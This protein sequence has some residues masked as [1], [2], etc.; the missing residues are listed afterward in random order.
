MSGTT[1]AAEAQE[2]YDLRMYSASETGSTYASMTSWTTIIKNF[3]PEIWRDVNVIPSAGPYAGFRAFSQGQAEGTYANVLQMKELWNSIGNFE[4][5]PIPENKR[6]LLGPCLWT[7]Q[8]WIITKADS[9]DIET[10]W[11]LEGK[12]VSFCLPGYNAEKIASKIND[13]LEIGME[14]VFIEMDAIADA[15]RDGVIDAVWAY[16]TSGFS[17]PSWFRELELRMDA[18]VIPLTEKD[19]N[20]ISEEVEGI[21]TTQIEL[22]NISDRIEG[23][24]KFAV[25]NM[26]IFWVFSPDLPEQAAYEICEALYEKREEVADSYAAGVIWE[27]TPFELQKVHMSVASDM[28]LPM[29][30][31]VAKWLKDNNVWNEEWIVGEK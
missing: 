13:T 15:L 1:L 29:H 6:A 2:K 5:N 12:K 24:E 4:D 28:G 31:G 22:K 18:K 19:V 16:S 26:G 21:S 23:P 11:D 27:E 10:M 25:P 20:L 14:K 30:P 9:D 17:T 7:H 3:K 8:N